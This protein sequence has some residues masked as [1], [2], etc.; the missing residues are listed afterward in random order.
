MIDMKKVIGIT[1]GIASGKSTVSNYLKKLGYPL[2]DCDELTKD[3]YIDCFKQIE[4]TFPDCIVDGE[5][6]REK[7][8]QCV[9][10][11][12]AAKKKLEGIIHPYVRK[13]MEMFIE[14]NNRII[15]L[16]IPLLFEANMEDLCDEIWVVYVSFETQLERLMKRNQMDEKTAMMRI[17]AQMS[18]EEKK[19]RADVVLN[20][21]TTLNNL[22][23]Q[24]KERLEVLENGQ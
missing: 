5:I 12:T 20:N 3:S 13:R 19:N 1:G 21:E 15:F 10:S 6:S 8:G 2:I 16:D 22:Y 18:L 11:N 4:T 7:L 9:F 17:Y 24:I 14:E 23:T